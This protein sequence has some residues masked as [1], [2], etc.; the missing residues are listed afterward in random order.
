MKQKGVL[1]EPF[2]LVKANGKPIGWS[3]ILGLAASLLS[4]PAQLAREYGLVF[5]QATWFLNFGLPMAWVG[6]W[7][8][9]GNFLVD[10][11]FYF[12]WWPFLQ[13]SLFWAAVIFAMIFVYSALRREYPLPLAPAYVVALASARI[14][15]EFQMAVAAKGTIFG[16]ARIDIFSWAHI[17]AYFAMA[18]LLFPAVIAVTSRL[19]FTEIFKLSSL[20]FPIILV[21][22]T[23]D[24]YVLRAPVIYNFFT[25]GFRLQLTDPFK[26]LT[27]L[28]PGIKLEI[29]L[30][31][32]S[33]FGYLVYRRVS[34]LR[35]IVAILGVVFAF[36]LVSTP[37]LTSQLN[38]GF[39]QPQL[40]AG[41][42]ILTYVLSIL[43]FGLADRNIGSTILKRI[44]VRG[45]HFPAM[46]V[47][48]SFIVHP[49]ILA[50]GIPEDFG[51][52]I[53]GAFIVFLVWQTAVVFDDI[54]DRGETG[55]SGYLGY[56]ILSATMAVLATVPYGLLPWLLTT[57]A[58]YFAVDYPR[59]RRKH[60]LFSGL[61]VGISSCMAFLFGTQ[62]L[63]TSPSSSQPVAF[64]ALAVFLVFSGASLLKDIVNIEGDRRSGISTVFTR[65]QT[66]RVLPIVAGF[67]AVGFVL[68][69]VLFSTLLDQALFLAIG[70]GVW[71]LIMVAKHR[72][73]KPVLALYFVEGLWVF[74][75]VFI[76]PPG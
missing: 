24:Y 61:V 53:A 40:F 44:R 22:P 68:P 49:S 76:N 37:V 59:L 57:L 17:T 45:V 23:V 18:L 7:K 10:T 33:T 28:S 9:S 64:F 12:Y 1:A 43:D 21:P 48:G 11:G 4:V 14:Q 52:I 20:G 63:V 16:F 41:Y 26:Y 73:Y 5:S 2:E 31:A 69:T 13:N 66:N 25:P 15:L 72:S 67:V 50:S 70:A 47:F 32:M 35:V 29:V 3:L 46:A 71:L 6:I 75:R 54:Y 34:I 62:M 42:L 19:K 56:G 60:Y 74:F 39:S 65:F 36:A 51:L 30:V 55:M 27:I 38:L 8:R 58:V